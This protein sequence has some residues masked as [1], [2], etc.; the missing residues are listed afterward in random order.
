MNLKIKGTV[1]ELTEVLAQMGACGMLDATGNDCSHMTVNPGMRLLIEDGRVW[2]VLEG[3]EVDFPEVDL[4]GWPTVMEVV[5]STLGD[6]HIFGLPMGEDEWVDCGRPH[7]WV[8]AGVAPP[9]FVCME[10]VGHGG[11]LVATRFSVV[12]GE[13][14]AYL[15]GVVCLDKSYYGT[16]VS[17]FVDYQ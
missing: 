1:E 13:D 10:D 16:D 2:R 12:R 14:F 11:V 17:I 4:S 6:G 5:A 8:S 7:V 15:D 9:G 3:L